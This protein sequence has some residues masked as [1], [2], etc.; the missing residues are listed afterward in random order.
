M[1]ASAK[2]MMMMMIMMIMMVG[3]YFFFIISFILEVRT[4]SLREVI[5]LAQGYTALKHKSMKSPSLS[6]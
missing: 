2:M 3:K 4:L 5:R 1:T 6:F